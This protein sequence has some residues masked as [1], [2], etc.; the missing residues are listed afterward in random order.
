MNGISTVNS[1]I[2]V[3]NNFGHQSEINKQ[4]KTDLSN[5][6]PNRE[7]QYLCGKVTS[8]RI[9]NYQPLNYRRYIGNPLVPGIFFFWISK[10]KFAGKVHHPMTNHLGL[11]W[12]FFNRNHWQDLVFWVK[13]DFALLKKTSIGFFHRTTKFKLD[14][15]ILYQLKIDI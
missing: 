12:I 8:I 15:F 11:K 7:C 6:R 9:L 1:S 3:S 10:P 2:P 13:F 4:K 5:K 14:N